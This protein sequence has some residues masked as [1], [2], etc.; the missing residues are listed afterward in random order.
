M[1]TILQ[2]ILDAQEKFRCEYLGF[3]DSR[4]YQLGG[5]LLVSAFLLLVISYP[6]NLQVLHHPQLGAFGS[7]CEEYLRPPVCASE[8]FLIRTIHRTAMYILW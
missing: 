3:A 8:F 2:P 7:G 6:A 1:Q 5:M 4:L